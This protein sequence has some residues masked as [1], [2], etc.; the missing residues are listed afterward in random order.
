MWQII[1]FSSLTSIL[2]SPSALFRKF[3]A[4]IHTSFSRAM[5]DPFSHPISSSRPFE[6]LLPPSNS[7]PHFRLH[8]D[9]PTT[10]SCSGGVSTDKMHVHLCSCSPATLRQTRDCR[11]PS[12]YAEGASSD[13]HAIASISC[14]LD[15]RASHRNKSLLVCNAEICIIRKNFIIWKIN[16]TFINGL[17]LIQ[18]NNIKSVFNVTYELMYCLWDVFK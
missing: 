13:I 6:I 14:G 1:F 3:F 15:C 4:Y 16:K 17:R 2:C 10:Q 18:C 11:W 9:I 5:E 8:L 7:T 12:L